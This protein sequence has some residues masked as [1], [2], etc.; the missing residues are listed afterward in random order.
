MVR[1]LFAPRRDDGRDDG[2][3][4]GK[5]AGPAA[6]VPAFSAATRLAVLPALGGGF[7]RTPNR[8]DSIRAFFGAFDHLATT[9]RYRSPASRLEDERRRSG[10]GRGSVRRPPCRSA[11]AGGHSGGSLLRVLPPP[12]AKRR[13]GRS[14]WRRLRP[15]R[16]GRT[17]YAP[18]SVRS[19]TWRP[20]GD[21][22]RPLPGSRTNGGGRDPGAARFDDLLVGPPP[23][24]VTRA[25]ASSAFFRRHP[26]SA[27]AD[28]P[29]GGGF[30]RS[31][32]AG[33]DTRLLRCVRPRGDTARPLPGSMTNVGGQDLGS[34]RFDDLLLGPPPGGHSGGSVLAFSATGRQA[35]PRT[36]HLAAVSTGF[37]IGRTRYPPSSVRS[38]T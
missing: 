1:S 14:T 12:S 35:P 3:D 8:Q 5:E 26:R 24:A 11:A 25:E 2:P 9:W 31:E 6:S 38:T 19:T 32:S 36:I 7:D 34:A 20:P 27:A 18:S 28:D 21:T 22:A 33:R 4:E 37:R 17:R 30:D 29:L 16:I 23:P 10:P 15:V 13:R